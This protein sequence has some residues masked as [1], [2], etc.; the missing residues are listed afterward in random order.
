MSVGNNQRDLITS[1]M[2]LATASD[3]IAGEIPTGLING[4]NPV[5]LAAHDFIPESV[6]VYVNGVMQQRPDEFT[7]SGP[8]TIILADSP[9]VNEEV[10]ICYTRV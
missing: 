2:A 1:Q 8:R 10:L 9:G 6:V 5:F 7:T 4:S 3:E